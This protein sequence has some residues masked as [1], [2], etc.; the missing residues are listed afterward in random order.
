MSIQGVSNQPTTVLESRFARENLNTQITMAVMKQVQ[1]TQ[2]SQ[3]Q[4]LVQMINQST[5]QGTGQFLNILA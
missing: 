4:A 1:D 2:E 5:P 3:A